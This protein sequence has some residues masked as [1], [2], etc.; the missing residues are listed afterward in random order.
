MEGNLEAARCRTDAGVPIYF[1]K[2]VEGRKSELPTF[3]RLVFRARASTPTTLQVSLITTDAGAAGT[4]VPVGTEWKEIASSINSLQ[5]TGFLLLPRPYPGFQPLL[6]KTEGVK[7]FH[8]SAAERLEIR[9]QPS[10]G[11]T[12]SPLT[13]EVGAVWLA[14]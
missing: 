12:T 13:V 8:L 7:P 1:G 2:K 6:F 3:T 10:A 14:K 5:P 11:G 4:A 9:F